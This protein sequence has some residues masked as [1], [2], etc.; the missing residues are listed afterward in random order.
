M[1]EIPLHL[2]ECMICYEET[3]K[4]IFFSCN[5]KVCPVCFPKLHECPLCQSSNKVKVRT[6]I[7]I[8]NISPN[9]CHICCSFIMIFMFCLWGF[10]IF[11]I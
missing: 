3:D 2:E 7:E 1:I 8:R 5:H 6:T 9:Y 11:K 10:H 4:Y